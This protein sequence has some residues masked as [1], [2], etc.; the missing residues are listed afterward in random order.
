M[1]PESALFW[2]EMR[3]DFL[4]TCTRAPGEGSSP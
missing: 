3:P 1:D 4:A 2:D